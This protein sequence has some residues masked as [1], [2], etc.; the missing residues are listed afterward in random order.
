MR[1]FLYVF[2]AAILVDVAH[3]ADSNITHECHSLSKVYSRFG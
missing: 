1:I 3:F 2:L